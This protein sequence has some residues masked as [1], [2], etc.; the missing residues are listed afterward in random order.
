MCYLDRSSCIALSTYRHPLDSRRIAL[1]AILTPHP[2]QM[3]SPQRPTDSVV[4][5]EPILMSHRTI[6]TNDSEPILG[7]EHFTRQAVPNALTS[8]TSS[9]GSNDD[10]DDD[11]DGS[12]RDKGARVRDDTTE[13]FGTSCG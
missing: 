2:F 6:S 1:V 12:S 10:D 5:E 3:A 13:K 7:F 9:D 11:D 4:L 8:R